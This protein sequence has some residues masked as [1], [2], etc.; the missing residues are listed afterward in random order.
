MLESYLSLVVHSRDAIHTL[1]RRRGN[2]RR[3]GTIF[4]GGKIVHSQ[5]WENILD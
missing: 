5:S 2:E 1:K 4:S 3:D